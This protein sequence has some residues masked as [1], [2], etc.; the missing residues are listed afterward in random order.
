[1]VGTWNS[2]LQSVKNSQ[3]LSYDHIIKY[4]SWCLHCFLSSFAWLKSIKY[5]I[6]LNSVRVLKVDLRVIADAQITG[7]YVFA[8][9]NEKWAAC[10]VS[11]P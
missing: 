3:D 8:S 9:L 1:M 4:L 7:V 2:Y 6:S 10:K 11:V 5:E